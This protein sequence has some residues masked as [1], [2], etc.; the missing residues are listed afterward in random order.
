VSTP[1][2]LTPADA[3]ALLPAGGR[4]YVGGCTAEPRALYRV[5]RSNPD[6]WQDV[7]LT[8]SFIPGVNDAD[9]SALGRGTTVET[10]FST[11]GL[12]HPVGRV[13][14]LPLHYSTF[15]HR[16]SRPG[17]IDV[18][19]V[20]TPL[21]RAD[22]TVGLGLAADFALAP[23][24][25]G[26][27]L[28]A[29]LNPGMPDVANGPRFP[30]ARCAALVAVDE[31]LPVYDAGPVDPATAAIARI[32]VSLLRPGDRLQLGLG[33]VQAAVL[34]ALPGSG[35][36]GLGFHGGMVST[37]MLGALAAGVFSAGVT[38]GVA[39]G[40]AGFY[41]SIARHPDL[42]FAP[43]GETHSHAVLASLDA[44]VSVNSVIEIDLDGQANA[45]AIAG[46]QVSGHGGLV[47]FLRG[48][49]AAPNGRGILALAS[50]ARGGSVSRI[51]HRLAE[52]TP[53]SVARS[54]ADI[55]VTEHGVAHLG[56]LSLA[57]RAEILTSIADPTH[58][59]GLRRA[60]AAGGA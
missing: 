3:A 23:I 8:G 26:A 24:S 25:A 27:I 5:V 19:Y 37:P 50:T 40:S 48:A 33:K 45:E 21:P 36:R 17:F 15:Y 39:L 10:I 4:A 14:F 6:L 42:R 53:V 30:L 16:L 54:D 2:V 49:R 56:G 22:G 18:V 31:P 34:E 60:V 35:L 52:G 58:R 28:V 47:D 9:L 20:T 32:I 44:F 12:R 51:V 46:V 29:L 7:V 11:P 1:P 43:V 13:A 57:R 55:V 38:T 41:D 59:E